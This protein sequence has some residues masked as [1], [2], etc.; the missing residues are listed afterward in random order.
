[1]SPSLSR[2]EGKE[3]ALSVLAYK[4]EAPAGGAVVFSADWRDAP[5]PI[6]GRDLPFLSVQEG[7]LILLELSE[8]GRQRCC[9]GAEGG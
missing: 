1:M 6:L 3:W 8:S 7:R 9:L 5:V 4:N 2:F